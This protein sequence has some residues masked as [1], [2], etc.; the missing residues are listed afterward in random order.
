MIRP[1]AGCSSPAIRRSVV[2]LP[3]PVGPRS[4]KNSPSL[5]V[6][7][8]AATAAIAPKR[9]LSPETAISAMAGAL[10]QGGAD[11]S[12]GHAVEDRGA[13]GAEREADHVAGLR[14]DLGR[15]PR[16]D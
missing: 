15:E 11:G 8:I 4:T 7:S 2:V 6:R 14:R 1:A 10:L 16:L 5:M 9:L 3:A 12:A 13:L